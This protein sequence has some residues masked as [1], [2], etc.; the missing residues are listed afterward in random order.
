MLDCEVVSLAPMDD[1]DVESCFNSLLTALS[2]FELTAAG[3]EGV[4]EA[5]VVAA[6]TG[7]LL[8]GGAPELGGALSDFLALPAGTGLCEEPTWVASVAIAG[9]GC[10]AE[11]GNAAGVEG[12]AW[13]VAA[14]AW[15]SC[16]DWLVALSPAAPTAEF[17][18]GTC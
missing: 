8:A 11:L 9:A 3:S 12:V 5:V 13:D 6:W 10:A 15:L 17:A 1:T 18:G 7:M 2:C 4:A 14:S 16:D